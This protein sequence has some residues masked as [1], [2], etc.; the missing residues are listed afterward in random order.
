MVAQDD[1][2]TTKT[3]IFIHGLPVTSSSYIP[4]EYNIH[5]PITDSNSRRNSNTTHLPN[6]EPVI[7]M[8]FKSIFGRYLKMVL[9]EMMKIDVY[10]T[11]NGLG[12]K[13]HLQAIKM[14]LSAQTLP[15]LHSVHGISSGAILSIVLVHILSKPLDDQLALL[16]TIAAQMKMVVKQ[17]WFINQSI[18]AI[19]QLVYTITGDDIHSRCTSITHIYYWVLT[20]WTCRQV[21]ESQWVSKD[22]LFQAIRKSCCVPLVGMYPIYNRHSIFYDGIGFMGTLPAPDDH[23]TIIVSQ[24]DLFA[25]LA[26][27]VYTPPSEFDVVH[28]FVHTLSTRSI[29]FIDRLHCTT[30][31]LQP[32][33][34][35]FS[36]WINYC[37]WFLWLFFPIWIGQVCMTLK[38]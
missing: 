9:M 29:H 20:T 37:T 19:L 8:V 1:F 23:S 4:L 28:S 32:Y 34:H 10:L 18:A 35:Q 15:I 13:S 27:T 11:G 24:A 22:D 16:Y 2:V 5:N 36:R 31:I 30:I 25:T 33:Q 38:I 3:Y 6:R 14:V 12:L 17:T 7:H 21:V 26:T